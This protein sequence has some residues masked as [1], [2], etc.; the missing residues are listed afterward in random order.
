LLRVFLVTGNTGITSN[1]SASN[2]ITAFLKPIDK[3]QLSASG[4]K[5]I[6]N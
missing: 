4:S 2:N 3:N 1:A 5:P 6:F